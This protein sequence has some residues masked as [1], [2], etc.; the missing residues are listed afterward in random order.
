MYNS[1]FTND[2]LLDRFFI[3]FTDIE[4][5]RDRREVC[6]DTLQG[7]KKYITKLEK[8][9]ITFKTNKNIYSSGEGECILL[10]PEFY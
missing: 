9:K 7:R 1:T 6:D 3:W 10:S 8:I 2:I 4:I 5:H